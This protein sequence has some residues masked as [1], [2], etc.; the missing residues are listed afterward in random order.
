MKTK[1]SI[2]SLLC[3]VAL[4][5][6]LFAT[7]SAI[8]QT[9]AVDRSVLG[10]GGGTSTNAQFSV[11]GTIGQPDATAP[12]LGAGPFLLDGGFWSMVIVIQTPGAPTLRVT[13]SGSNVVVSWNLPADG[14]ALEIT[15][16]FGKVTTTWQ[17]VGSTPVSADNQLSVTLPLQPGARYYRLKRAGP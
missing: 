3:G 7:N 9:Y 2:W 8:A 6:Q 11:T 16:Q 5:A 14:F 13:R 10:G 12:A 15:D 4:A 1:S 17:T